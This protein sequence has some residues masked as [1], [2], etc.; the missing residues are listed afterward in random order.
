M[1]KLLTITAVI[2][3][4]TFASSAEAK[5]KKVYKCNSKACVERVEWKNIKKNPLPACTYV[6]ESGPINYRAGMGPYGWK[7]YKVINKSS[8]AS[9]K[10]QIMNYTWF[11]F[12][13]RR[14][15]VTYHVAASATPLEQ[16]RMARKVYRNQ[17][18]RAWHGC[19]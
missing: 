18:I 13:G 4:L 3:T 14:T 12:G 2:G 11:N 7:R 16:E 15:G 19:W 9:G 8:S 6:N 1:N 10:Y 17:G 5:N